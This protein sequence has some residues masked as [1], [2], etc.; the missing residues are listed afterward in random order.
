MFAVELQTNAT[1]S[2][3]LEVDRRSK[4]RQELSTRSLG[5]FVGKHFPGSAL[6]MLL[7]FC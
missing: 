3:L 7:D 1:A 4:P 5:W 2:R 6:P